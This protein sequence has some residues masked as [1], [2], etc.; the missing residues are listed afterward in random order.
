[1]SI[2]SAPDEPIG[3]VPLK[4]DAGIIGLVA[5]AHAAS[6]FGHLLLPPL[7]PVFMQTFEL[8]YA[9]LGLLM[10][11]FFVISGIGQALAGFAVDRVGARPLMFV[12]IALFM[13]VCLLAASAGSYAGLLIVAA[14]SGLA[15]ATFHPVDFTILNQRV[16]SARLGHAYSAHGLAGNLG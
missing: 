13:L 1:M 15:N 16:S 4:Q 11:V 12:A 7:F 10:T 3:V 2:A 6:H 8:G 5:M 14:L 9:Q